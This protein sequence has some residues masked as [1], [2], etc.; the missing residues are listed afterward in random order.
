M[1]HTLNLYTGD[2]VKVNDKGE[3][4]YISRKDFQIKH[5]GY[6]I[7]LGE[8]ENVIN[9]IEGIIMCVCVYDFRNKK[10]VL[11]YQAKD[12]LT[13]ESLIQQA[14]D[15]LLSYM[16]PGRF[17]RLEKMIYNSNGKIDRN[18]LKSMI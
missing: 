6:R 8:I 15:K 2:L 10:I 12:E 16:R 14:K 4:I 18:K 9:S 1:T 3:I 5:M 11:F 13:E 7:E 17:E